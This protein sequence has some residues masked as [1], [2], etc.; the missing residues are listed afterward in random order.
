M[1]FIIKALDYTKKHS[2]STSFF[3]CPLPP[4]HQWLFS[5]WEECLN[6]NAIRRVNYSKSTG[7]FVFG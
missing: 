2:L 6:M 1:Q 3:T 7:L 5:E 4:N